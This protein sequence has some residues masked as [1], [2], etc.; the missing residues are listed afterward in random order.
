MSQ[1]VTRVNNKGKRGPHKKNNFNQYTKQHQASIKNMKQDC[2]ATSSILGLYNFLDTK[3]EVY[4]ENNQEY[5]TNCEL[6]LTETEPKELTD[7]DFDCINLW[8]Y[9]KD[10]FSISN[11]AWHELAV[12]QAKEIPNNYKIGERLKESNANWTFIETRERQGL[13]KYLLKIE[14]QASGKWDIKHEHYH[15]DQDQW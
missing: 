14:K 6:Q 9:I 3:I 13:C 12:N 15:Q 11:K 4:N 7:D 8:I 10:K 5:E 2:Q 1:K